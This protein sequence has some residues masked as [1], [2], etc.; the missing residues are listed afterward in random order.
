MKAKQRLIV[1]FMQRDRWD[2]DQRLQA[3]ALIAAS[4]V[5]F[6]K[7]QEDIGNMTP[8]QLRAIGIR[9]HAVTRMDTE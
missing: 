2:R 7:R 8:V 3:A 1:P 4:N 5:A 6:F 9:S